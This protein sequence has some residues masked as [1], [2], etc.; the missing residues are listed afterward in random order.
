MTNFDI[1]VLRHGDRGP[2]AAFANLLQGAN[3]AELS[4]DLMRYRPDG[5]SFV[6]DALFVE[7]MLW[8][9]AQDG[10]LLVLL[11]ALLALLAFFAIHAG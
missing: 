6:M 5:P 8:S 1:A 3:W 7:L 10:L 2:V 11:G 9:R 4:L